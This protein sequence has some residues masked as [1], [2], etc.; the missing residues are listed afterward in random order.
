MEKT[1]LSSARPNRRDALKYG[2]GF[3]L[4]LAWP[5]SK[6]LGANDDIRVGVIGLRGRGRAH[7]SGYAEQKGVR[8]TALCDCDPDVLDARV[9]KL[10]DDQGITVEGFADMREMF[11]KGEIDAMSSA[12]PNHWHS[13]SGIWAMQAGIDAYVE[14]PISHNVWEGRQLVKLARQQGRI[15]Q[16]GT[17][18]RAIGAIH[19][20]VAKLRAG[21]YGAIK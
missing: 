5:N 7:M 1:R 19:A 18:S 13:L 17:Q 16:G 11:E 20:T 9:T 8:V 12:T 2:A 3:G 6:V 21:D 14:K 10:T 15:C 4:A